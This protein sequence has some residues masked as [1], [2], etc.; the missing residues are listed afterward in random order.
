MT[1][2]ISP[3]AAGF[4]TELAELLIQTESA[5]SDSANLQRDAARKDFLENA[6]HQIDALHE[7][8]DD[9]R[10]GAFVS[11]A[12]TVAGAACSIASAVDQYA[13]DKQKLPGGLE[14]LVSEKYLREIPNDPITGKPDWVPVP[15]DDPNSTTGESGV[16]D[17]HSA[18]EEASS[19]GSTYSSW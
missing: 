1:Q 16:V 2:A 15:G 17:V 3:A 13:A 7:A 6:Q 12:F 10:S 5:Q 19:D 4:A 8:A 11:A 18:A 9:V 14:D